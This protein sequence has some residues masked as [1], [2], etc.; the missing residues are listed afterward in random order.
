MQLL[1]IILFKFSFVYLQ[2]SSEEEEENLGDTMARLAKKKKVSLMM[3]WSCRTLTITGV[4]SQQCRYLFAAE[5]RYILR[6]IL[7]NEASKANYS[8]CGTLMS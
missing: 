8:Q 3:S 4:P 6:Q 2:Y 1:N 5:Y 7:V